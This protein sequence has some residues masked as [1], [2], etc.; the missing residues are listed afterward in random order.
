MTFSTPLA[1]PE[2][3]LGLRW[4]GWRREPAPQQAGFAPAPVANESREGPA[5]LPAEYIP[6]RIDGISGEMIPTRTC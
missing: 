4:I 3:S 5:W 2:A 6:E 1:T